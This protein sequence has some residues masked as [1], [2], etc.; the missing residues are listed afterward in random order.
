MPEFLSAEKGEEKTE[1]EKAE[2]VRERILLCSS[3]QVLHFGLKIIVP[4]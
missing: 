3:S 2:E 4:L 1:A